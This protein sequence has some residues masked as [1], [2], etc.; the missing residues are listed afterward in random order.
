MDALII[1]NVL[2]LIAIVI[3]FVVEVFVKAKIVEG[4][5]S[6]FAKALE[7]HRNDLLIQRAKFEW[8]RSEYKEKVA[9][10]QRLGRLIAEAYSGLS[11]HHALYSGCY[12]S[13]AVGKL[14][15]LEKSYSDHCL[16]AHNDLYPKVEAHWIIW[17]D[18][19]LNLKEFAHGL[20]IYFPDGFSKPVQELVGVF[21]NL[22]NPAM[23]PEDMQELARQTRGKNEDLDQ[24]RENIRE[25][26]DAL[27]IKRKPLDQSSVLMDSIRV[28]LKGEVSSFQ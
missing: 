27:W 17:K 12:A 20:E 2:V 3:K 19:M 28:H 10:F 24:L 13:L 5:K 9:L 21:E 6:T 22:I 18:V 14:S 1:T 15:G 4:V 16:L 23:M 25:Y 26:Y 7:S 8:Q 11:L